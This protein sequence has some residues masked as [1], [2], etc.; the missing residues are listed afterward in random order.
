MK[1]FISWSGDRSKIV[2]AALKSWLGDVFI[3]VQTWMSDHDIN[4]GS[5]WSNDLDNELESTNFGILCL[6]P[7]N[8][9]SAWLL[10]E[11]GSLA[12]IVK[13]SRVVPYRLTVSETDVEY[14]LA[15]FQGVDADKAGTQ[16]LLQSINDVREAKLEN[17]R[18]ERLFEI[19]WPSLERQLQSIPL[20][21]GASTP[22]RPDR[23]L[24]EEILNLV[25]PL[26]RPHQ[27]PTAPKPED[28]TTIWV[29]AKK[30]YDVSED[31]MVAMSTSELERYF[32]RLEARWLITMSSSEESLLEGK[33]ALADKELSRRKLSTAL[34]DNTPTPSTD[35][36]A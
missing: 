20:T 22:Q 14:P 7:E 30:I 23:A 27:T 16:K 36:G 1:I 21:Q 33:M 13:N 25:R 5:R 11:A 2:A 12:K 26:T 3:D 6:T 32:Y 18:L 24:L 31:E 15:Q 9:S 29:K 17:D 19:W 35:D 4:A 28:E 34:A 8:L 10:F